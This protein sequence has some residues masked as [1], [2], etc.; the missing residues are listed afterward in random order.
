MPHG[1][2]MAGIW[3]T[4]FEDDHLVRERRKAEAAFLEQEAARQGRRIPSLT[5]GA[6]LEHK[7]LSPLMQEV[8]RR[9]GTRDGRK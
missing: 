7:A 1:K 3:V 9:A 8:A 6:V 2:M 4:M 5:F